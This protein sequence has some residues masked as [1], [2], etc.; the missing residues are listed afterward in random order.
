MSHGVQ[1]TPTIC[2]TAA[3]RNLDAVVRHTIPC[4]PVTFPPP[5]NSRRRVI[6]SLVHSRTRPVIHPPTLSGNLLL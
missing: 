5:L 2:D 3:R 6:L 4:V 1:P